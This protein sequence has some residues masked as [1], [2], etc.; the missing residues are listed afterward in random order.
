MTAFENW[1]MCVGGL[2]F[3]ASFVV[4]IS[5]SKEL[6]VLKFEKKA[7]QKEIG[8][9]QE[10]INNLKDY[11]A[12][13]INPELRDKQHKIMCG[14]LM[15]LHGI[16]YQTWKRMQNAFVGRLIKQIRHL[17]SFKKREPQ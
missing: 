7:L 4:N 1:I 14:L 10:I 12:N 5:Q 17:K 8:R 13:A 2:F 3:V 15:E 6:K 11:E 16:D 9:K